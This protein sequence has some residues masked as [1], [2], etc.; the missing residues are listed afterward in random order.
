METATP[1]PNII[2]GIH[3]G[4]HLF[5]PSPCTHD[6]P[7]ILHA[8]QKCAGAVADMLDLQTP[9]LRLAWTLN[10]RSISGSVILLQTVLQAA[11]DWPEWAEAFL[12]ETQRHMAETDE[13]REQAIADTHE[14]ARLIAE[15]LRI[16][17][18]GPQPREIR[19]DGSEE[20]LF[21]RDAVAAV[22]DD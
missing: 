19:I 1:N 8:S 17:Y 11:L 13:E 15:R 10:P 18:S 4:E 2:N 3:Y 14:G 6:C 21:S 9:T 16:Q 22:R 5:D 20:P 7:P 12:R